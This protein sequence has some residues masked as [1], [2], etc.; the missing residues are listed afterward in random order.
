[1]QIKYIVIKDYSGKP[2]KYKPSEAF[3]G[4]QAKDFIGKEGVRVVYG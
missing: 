1:M 2:I 3:M 4:K